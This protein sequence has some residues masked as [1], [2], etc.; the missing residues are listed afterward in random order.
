MWRLLLGLEAKLRRRVDV[1]LPI[2]K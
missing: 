1:G 2:I